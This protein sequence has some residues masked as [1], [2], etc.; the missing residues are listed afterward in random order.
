MRHFT[1]GMLIAGYALAGCAGNTTGDNPGDAG[2]SSLPGAGNAPVQSGGNGPLGSG[3]SG[4]GTQQG[5]GGNQTTDPPFQG[6]SLDCAAPTTGKPVLRL[7]TR[8]EFENTLND[9]FPSIKGQWSNSL[10]AGRSSAQGFDNSASS[11]VG[12]QLASALLE[13]AESV[14]NAVTG[15]ALTNILSCAGA[16]DRACAEQFLSS[17]GA[18]LFRRPLTQAEKERYLG[19]FDSAI[20]ASDFKTAL[21]WVTVGLIQS[22]SAV[23]RSEIG[24]E[25]GGKRQLTPYEVA[26]ELAYTFTGSTPSEELLAKAADD[27]LG[28]LTATAKTMLM[29]DRGKQLLQRFFEAYTEYPNAAAAVKVNLKNADGQALAFENYGQDLVKETQAFIADILFTKQ[30]GLRE[31]LTANTTNPSQKLAREFYG[32]PSEPSQ[33]Y[34]ST[35]R[36]AGRG[37]GLLAQASLLAAHANTDASSPTRRGLFVY[38]NLLCQPPLTVPAN[39]P[40]LSQTAATNTTR[41]R[42]ELGHAT[43]GCAACHKRFDPIGFGFEHYDQA[44]RYRDTEIG[45]DGQPHPINA[46]SSVF[47][48]T[49]DPIFDFTTQEELAQGLAD[50]EVTYQCLAAYLSTYAFGVADACLGA[51]QVDAMRTGSLGIVDAYAALAQEPHFRERTSQ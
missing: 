24:T 40:P 49:F 37:I 47:G 29:S 17:Y 45:A 23:Y 6:F 32:F 34:A 19:Y 33:D 22:P 10:P 41:E 35:E 42:Y 15:S 1:L 31:L 2:G 51:S 38:H 39:V 27:K 7:L 26:T 48:P 36:P 13:T 25:S 11:V 12:A 30:G 43:G 9:V 50:L 16:A 46:A 20:A 28:D 18:R 14:A 8:F 3:G 4:A 5:E 21:K 44:G